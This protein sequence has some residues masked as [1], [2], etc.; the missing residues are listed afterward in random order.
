M[1]H[2]VEEN[3]KAVRQQMDLA[4]QTS[5]RKIEDVKLLLA[6]KTV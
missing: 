6:T 2:L 5:G 3:L 1:E 4:C